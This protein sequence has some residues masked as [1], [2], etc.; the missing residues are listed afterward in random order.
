MKPNRSHAQLNALG[1]RNVAGTN[2]RRVG[3]VLSKREHALNQREQKNDEGKDLADPPALANGGA[4]VAA[5]HRSEE[6]ADKGYRHP[7]RRHFVAIGLE[8]ALDAEEEI[9]AGENS[10]EQHE[11]GNIADDDGD[12]GFQHAC[13]RLRIAPSIEMPGE[14]RRLNFLPRAARRDQHCRRSES[15]RRAC[16]AAQFCFREPLRIRLRPMVQ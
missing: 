12:D 7:K 2:V 1:K 8:N 6:G 15:G 4:E 16:R 13:F 11:H 14:S 5:E 3:I 10:H 9:Q